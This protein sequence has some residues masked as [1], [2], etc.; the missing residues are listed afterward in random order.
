MYKIGDE[1]RCLLDY[2]GWLGT[3]G[4]VVMTKTE[5]DF[6][7]VRFRD[8]PDGYNEITAWTSKY[9]EIVSK[10]TPEYDEYDQSDD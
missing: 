3:V 8:Q 10:P 7:R 5:Y 2:N 4:E 9:L 6:I 1:V